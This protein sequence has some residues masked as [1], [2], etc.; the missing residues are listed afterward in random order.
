MKIVMN[1]KITTTVI[2][3]LSIAFIAL[4][5][6][7]AETNKVIAI[8]APKGTQVSFAEGVHPVATFKFRDVIVTHDFQIFSQTSGFGNAGRGFTPEFTLL[9]VIGDTPYLHRAVEQTNAYSI[10]S[11]ADH[12]YKEFDVTVDIVQEGK[13]LL[14]QDYQRCDISNYKIFTEFDK[15]KSFTG[16]EPIA[17]L[18]QYTFTCAGY[19]LK[20]P[21]YEEM[22]KPK[23]PY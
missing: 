9:K 8:D 13:T 23:S 12:Q 21:M 5:F 16:K 15:S 7:L 1:N 22:M 18:E 3:A 19:Q 14:I 6:E 17:I 10:R 11:G 4:I 2:L 20:S